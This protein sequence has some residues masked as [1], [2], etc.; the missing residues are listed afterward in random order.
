LLSIISAFPRRTSSHDQQQNHGADDGIDDR[1]NSAQAKVDVASQH[2]EGAGRNERFGN[3]SL[4]MA[5]GAG[6][7][8]EIAR[9]AG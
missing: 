5:A 8:V 4:T 9:S 2:T 1:G 3:Y 7:T 6:R